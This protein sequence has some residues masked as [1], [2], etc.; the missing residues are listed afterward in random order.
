MTIREK[1]YNYFASR[2]DL[3]VLFVFDPMDMV[4]YEIEQCQDPWPED[5]VYHTFEGDWFT[6]KVKL[7]GEW[8]EKKVVMVFR[9][10]EPTTQDTCINF[11]LMGAL[12][13]NMVFHEEDAIAFMQ[14]R[15][16]PMEYAD[17]FKR[18]ITELLRDKFNKVLAPLYNNATAFSFDA[19]YRGILSAY[20]DSGKMLEWYQIIAR[21]IIMS[22]N[23]DTTK[24]NAFWG[25]LA[26]GGKIRAND[27][28][29]ALK[30]KTMSL[31][32]FAYDEMSGSPM[33]K[34]AEAMKYNAITQ[35][36]AMN[37]ADPY[38]HLKIQNGVRL[39][40][41]NTILSSI[42]ENTKLNEAFAPAI[43]HL[44]QNIKEETLLDVYGTDAHYSFVSEKMGREM[45]HRLIKESLYSHP[46][47][48]DGRLQGLE[49]NAFATD[50]FKHTLALYRGL[51]KYYG[52]VNAIG[53]LKLNTPDLYIA[54]YADQL[55]L[56]D[57]Y[58][59]QA[60]CAYAELDLA[61]K[62]ELADQTKAKLDMDYAAIINELNL[63]W[64]RCIKELGTGFETVTSIER[65]P[66][67]FRNRLQ[68]LK[69]KTAVIVSDALRY[70]M[71]QEL[72][73]QLTGKKHVA[74][75]T[76][77]LAMLPTETKY[78]KPSLLPHDTLACTGEDME[79]DGKVLASTE[80]RTA[81]LQ[82]RNDD[83]LCIG[84]KQLMALSKTEKREV[85]KHKLVYVFH[86]T[87]DEN[88]HGCSLKTFASTCK[89]V[90]DEL[91][92]LVTFIHDQANVTEVFITADHGFLYNDMAFEEKDKQAI[93]EDCT[94]KTTR[95]YIGHSDK[96]ETGITK[97][98]MP[99]V[100]AMKGD[101][102][103][104]V[105]TGTNRLAVKGGDYA[106]AH[107]GAS[108]EELV[109]PVIHSRYKRV[110]AKQKVS[111]TLLEPTLTIASSRLK[112][113]LVQG[114][115]VSMDMQELTVLCAVYVGDKPVTPVKTITLNSTDTEMGASR[116]YEVDLTVTQSA[117]SKI[118]QFKV[119]KKDDL[120]NPVIEKNIVN[121]TLIEQD[122][123]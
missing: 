64:V 89:D 18:H 85:F 49:Q 6:T 57:M 51:C 35:Q 20:L 54:R 74:T 31:V 110:N 7:A 5:Y 115:A 83:S 65:Q 11:P 121:N 93:T 87:L 16:I 38:K 22:D 37:E 96:E 47:E 109:I 2:A 61:S 60:V 28:Q 113:H 50:T 13:A 10:M 117:T 68:N 59:R 102:Y 91:V 106:F 39:Q 122:D 69:Q 58:Y 105:P 24:A 118:M 88:C 1:I 81:Q 32:G 77:A 67:F 4:R 66:D 12:K 45:A 14:Q 112:A 76:P 55:H 56:L 33:K 104:G 80:A 52:T 108:L 95:Y 72:M 48:V 29:M 78:C 107:G 17:F 25:K 30:E 97:F 92:Q 94:D 119:F 90:F 53:T 19:C 41:L 82:K 9:Q 70:E 8:K 3:R 46:D 27:V 111:V 15:G 36:L 62:T 63:E 120:L 44:A 34:V 40:E 21:I 23:E 123:F 98:P 26:S 84:Y 101:Y 103:I 75:L 99:S 116:I 42:A 43:D 71:A 73:Q 86:N 79:V 100:A 114:E